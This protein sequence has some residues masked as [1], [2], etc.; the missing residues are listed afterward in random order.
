[1][2][3]IFGYLVIGAIFGLLSEE[4]YYRRSSEA[5]R[6]PGDYVFSAC[7]L[8]IMWPLVLIAQSEDASRKRGE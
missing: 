4:R 6:T 7:A 1:M 3:W 5:S 2:L 8:A